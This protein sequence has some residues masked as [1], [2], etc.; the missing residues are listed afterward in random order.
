MQRHHYIY[1]TFLRE[2]CCCILRPLPTPTFRFFRRTAD[3]DNYYNKRTTIYST[4]EQN[5]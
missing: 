2:K 4:H 1:E 3:D 5:L